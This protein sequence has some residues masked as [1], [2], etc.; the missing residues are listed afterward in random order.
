MYSEILLIS[1]YRNLVSLYK[2]QGIEITQ[3]FISFHSFWKLLL[4]ELNCVLL[5]VLNLTIK[6]F[7][8]LHRF[9]MLTYWR[10]L[11]L[12]SSSMH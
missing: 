1:L 2:R 3:L 4:V 6:L 11:C 5:S 8:S 9:L 10:C 7:I 12:F